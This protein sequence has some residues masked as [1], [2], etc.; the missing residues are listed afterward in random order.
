MS[1]LFIPLFLF[2]VS[3]IIST[4]E[5][6]A[7]PSSEPFVSE[8][9]ISDTQGGFNGILDND[10]RFGRS[11]TSIGDFDGDGVRDLAVGA[12]ADDDGGLDRGAVW[13]LFLNSDG[14]VK[15]EQKIS[16]TQG[17]FNGILDNADLFGVNVESMEDLDGDGVTD[18]AVCSFWDDD[19]GL[20]RGAVWIL[21][22]NSDGTVK[23]HQKISDTQGGFTGVLDDEDLF[24]FG[25]ANMGDLDGDG[26]TDLAAGAR[27]D[28]DGGNNR[29][30]V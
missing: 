5:V 27:L 29:G 10:D 7:T 19:G 28:D 25:L 21:F 15:S 3:V 1:A 16:D 11:V 6:E 18:I 9:K 23:S 2:S 13:I 30:A 22:L 8:Q 12:R 14:T 17:G 24:G 20:N 4:V 26:V